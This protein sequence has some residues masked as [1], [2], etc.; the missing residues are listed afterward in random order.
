MRKIGL[1]IGLKSCG[2][3]LSDP[4][5][6]IAQGKENIKF[7]AKD[8]KS[9]FN[10][11][12]KYFEK[13]QIDTIVIG[14][15]KLASGEKSKTTLMIEEVEVL[16]KK[17]YL[18]PIKRIEEYFSTKKAHEILIKSGMSRKKRKNFKDQ[19]AAQILLND[20]LLTL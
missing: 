7:K 20:Y 5:N 8:W 15:P 16:L 12:D 19:I 14:Y 4:L 18:L 13:Y 3:A 10:K 2:V 6:I 1:D 17:R 9:M 11:L